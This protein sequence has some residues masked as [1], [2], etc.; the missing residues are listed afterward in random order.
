M[1]DDPPATTPPPSPPSRE[2][3]GRCCCSARWAW[4]SPPHGGPGHARRMVRARGAPW[5]LALGDEEE[6][7]AAY[8]RHLADRLGRSEKRAGN[9]WC[10]WYAYYENI[11]EELLTKDIT[12]LRG[13]PFDV[14]QVDDGWERIVGDWQ[15]NDKFPPGCGRWRTGSPRRGCG[16][17]C[18]SPRSS[19]T[20]SPV[21]PGSGRS[22]CCATSTARRW[23]PGT[24]GAPAT[25]R[26]T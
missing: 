13:L 7:F 8:A 15:P 9:V 10:S 23:S 1:W 20:P 19:S 4:T 2:P 3:T 16:P 25:G 24:T 14:V 17:A 26:S 18:G 6:V 22:C 21:P 5:F 12:A 11:T